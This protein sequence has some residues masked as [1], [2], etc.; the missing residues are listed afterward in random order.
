MVIFPY[1]KFVVR[2][3]LELWGSSGS[4]DE[5]TNGVFFIVFTTSDSAVINFFFGCTLYKIIFFLFIILL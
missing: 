5:G 3:N 1:G 4:R 2:Y